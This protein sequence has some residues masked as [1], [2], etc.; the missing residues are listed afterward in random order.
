M[1]ELKSLKSDASKPADATGSKAPPYAPAYSW[2]A[3]IDLVRP[4]EA[5]VGAHRIVTEPAVIRVT[6]R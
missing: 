1:S 2:R 6:Q 4:A 5:P 3:A